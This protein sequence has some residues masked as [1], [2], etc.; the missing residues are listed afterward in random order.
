M[1][2]VSAERNA[3]TYGCRTLFRATVTD[4][5]LQ[6]GLSNVIKFNLDSDRRHIVLIAIKLDHF[7]L[8]LS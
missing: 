5:Y 4:A 2:F 6:T 8:R 7:C 3:R 1:L